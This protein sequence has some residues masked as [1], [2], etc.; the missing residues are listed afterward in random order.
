MMIIKKP[1]MSEKSMQLAKAG[2]YT[3]L[4]DKDARKRD[5]RRAI[6]TMFNVKVISIKTANS[7]PGL[8]LQRSRQ[9]Y[10]KVG[11]VKK[12]VVTLSDK[13]KI[14]LFQPEEKEVEVKTAE[15]EVI[16]EK[17]SLLKGTKVKVEK[18]QA[19]GT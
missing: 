18:N 10:F 8:K 14:D 6:D 16:K 11:S 1:L 12:A 9:G 5:I 19:K 13:Q 2:R 15:S 3:F 4:V 7:K 17:K